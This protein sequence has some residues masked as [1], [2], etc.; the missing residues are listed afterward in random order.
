[1]EGKI[2]AATFTTLA[3]IFASMSG[4]TNAEIDQALPDEESWLNSITPSFEIIDRLNQNPEPETQADI[5]VELSEDHEL[6]F[7]ANELEVE[8]LNTLEGSIPVNSEEDLT[9]TNFNGVVETGNNT[10]ITGSAEGFKNSQMNVNSTVRIDQEIQTD[11][12]AAEGLNRTEFEFGANHV[13]L[14]SSDSGSTIDQ[15]NTI[16]SISSF[17]GDLEIRP[18]NKLLFDGFVDEVSSGSTTFG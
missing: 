13:L 16:V 9:L 3:I 14:E 17:S 15:S 12:I 8:G 10:K 4:G 2:V 5:E 6:S 1:M 11:R 18:P 7:T